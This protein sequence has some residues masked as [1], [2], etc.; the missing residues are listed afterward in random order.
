MK[1]NALISVSDKEGLV[2]FVRPLVEE[3]GY[4][5]ISTGGTAK[6]LREHS[7]PV[8]E[9]S[10]FTGFPELLEGRVKSLH[11][12]IH[13]G[14]L[15]RRELRSDLDEAVRHGIELIDL[16]A[17]NF[18]PFEQVVSSPGVTLEKALDAVDIGG[19][20]LIR[21]AAKNPASV[22]AISDPSDYNAVLAA[23]RDGGGKLLAELRHE[24]ALKTFRRC[25]SYDSAITRYFASERTTPDPDDLS[26]FPKKLQITLDKAATLRYGENPHQSAA[27]YGS[28]F[29]C[30]DQLQG[31]PLSYNNILDTSAAA[32]LIGEFKAPAAA[33]LKHAN[34]C[35]A[36]TADD[37]NDAWKMALATD[38][39]AAFG[40]IHVLNRT[41]DG[42][43]AEKMV[44]IFCEVVI[45]PGFQSAALD[46]F[47]KKK[48]L[49][50]LLAK[51]GLGPEALR[52]FRTVFGGLLAQDADRRAFDPT[53]CRVVTKLEPSSAQWEALVFAWQVV[54][55]VKS[56]AIVLAKGSRTL[57]IGAGQMSRLDA[58][59]LANWKKSQYDS[60]ENEGA[61]VVASDGFFP[62]A[63]GL[64]V[65][66]EAGATAVIQ[67]GGSI[68][69]P[70]VIEAANSLGMA[71]VFTGIRHFRH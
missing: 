36:A 13:A 37:V 3:F 20:C 8:T 68:R 30:F 7:L 55:H 6:L 21:S 48:N 62:F 60:L 40:G 12:K 42:D 38:P 4:R 59:R 15:C 28:F 26:G 22:M 17:V 39:Q 67:P 34:P 29:D 50:L 65:A 47:R 18:Y 71:M 32:S 11:P 54:K 53:K 61:I 41:V 10:T 24:L 14:L 16:V 23:L 64:E 31:K 66:A 19:P 57:G 5:I 46:I 35:G 69:D 49:R 1:K 33:I 70:E 43:L 27:L 9:V 2:D 63:D 25:A 52:E 45:A 44:E 58:A 56:N 51:G